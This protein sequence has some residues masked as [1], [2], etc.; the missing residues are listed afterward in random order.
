MAPIIDTHSLLYD[1]DADVCLSESTLHAFIALKAIQNP[2]VLPWDFSV[3]TCCTI[4]HDL[5]GFSSHLNQ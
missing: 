1:I 4:A 2:K 3:R 5:K